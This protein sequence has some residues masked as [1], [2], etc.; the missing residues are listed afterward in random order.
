MSVEVRIKCPLCD[1]DG[2]ATF[3]RL[4]GYTAICGTT[5]VAGLDPRQ[6]DICRVIASL[7]F[8]VAILRMTSGEAVA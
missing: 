8:E 1:T 6:T 5:W 4:D 2:W 3:A 7:R